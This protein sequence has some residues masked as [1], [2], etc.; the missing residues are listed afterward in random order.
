MQGHAQERK[1]RWEAVSIRFPVR[2]VQV[3]QSIESLLILTHAILSDP[4]RIQ[5]KTVPRVQGARFFCLEQSP[6]VFLRGAVRTANSEQ[7][8]FIQP[9]SNDH[10][11]QRRLRIGYLSPDFRSHPAGRFLLPLLGSHDHESFEIFCYASV[12]V[13][14]AITDRCRAH[15][16]VWRD[17]LG[18]PDV[19]VAGIIRQDRVDILVDLTMHMSKNRLLVFARKPA[20][21][22]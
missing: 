11:P 10:S 21:F 5:I 15:A 1:I 22:R 4:E 3:D 12:N 19:Q 6:C 14:D 2:F 9:H 8:L 16:D 20:P 18:L 17:L 13:P 7:G